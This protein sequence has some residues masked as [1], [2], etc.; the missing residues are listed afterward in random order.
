MEDLRKINSMQ[1]YFLWRSLAISLICI[2]VLIASKI[3][4]PHYMAPVVSLIICAVLY[5][6]M[7]NN[8]NNER[9]ICMVVVETMLYGF[10]LYTVVSISLVL[11]YVFDILKLP[12]EIIFFNDPYI[13][14]LLLT[15]CF[16]V[17]TLYALLFTKTMPSYKRFRII[18]GNSHETGYFGFISSRET[19]VQLRSLCVVFLV[20]S[21]V[22]WWY[23]LKVYVNINQNGRDWYI[24]SWT[25]ILTVV[26][27][28]LY[29]MMRYYNLYLDLQEHNEIISPEE[30]RDVTA[31]TYIRYYVICGEYV[32][33]DTEAFDRV[34]QMKGVTDTPFITK[35]TVNG[36]PT[37]EARTIIENMTG[38]KGGE[39]RF[40]FGRHLAGIDKHSLLRYFYFLDGQ[41]S[42]YGDLG[43]KG[44]WV[45]FEEIKN[46]YRTSPNRIAYNAL[47]DLSRLFTIILTERTFD[48]FGNRRNKIKSYHQNLTLADVRKTK[49]DLQDD[50][51]I[52]IAQFNSDTKFY[53]LKKFLRGLSG[54]N[55]MNEFEHKKG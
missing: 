49:I 10:M 42:D 11:F 12:N 15:P 25:V 20:L 16:F 52:H 7:W 41:P 37:S 36:V 51:W 47:S 45:H 19:H 33:V 18:Y 1:L 9:Q 22:I 29:F 44:K 5:T 39:L 43:E 55:G 27:G 26:F 14:S 32:Y 30:L 2:G 46:I 4:L 13:P 31:H 50:K 24:F 38:Q 6:M 17:C 21:I 35:R 54:V 40:Y 8:S 48:E 53:K 28:E 3:V 34:N 23:F